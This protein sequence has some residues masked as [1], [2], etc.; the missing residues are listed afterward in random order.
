VKENGKVEKG[1]MFFPFVG[2][3]NGVFWAIVSRLYKRINSNRTARFPKL[4]R[5]TRIS[6]HI[7]RGKHIRGRRHINRGTRISNHINRLYFR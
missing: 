1:W 7:N 5:G 6:K 3:Y 4:N 2:R